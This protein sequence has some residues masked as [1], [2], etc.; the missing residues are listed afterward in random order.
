MPIHRDPSPIRA[1]FT[2]VRNATIGDSR[3]SWEARGLLVF[4]LSKPDNWVVSTKHLVGQ[5]PNAKRERILKILAEL[6]SAGYI[7]EEQSRDG[8]S[9]EFGRVTRV[10]YDT[11]EG[12]S[13]VVSPDGTGVGFTVSGDTVHGDA[14][15][16]DSDC[17][18]ITDSEQEL[19]E[20]RTDRS[21][22]PAPRSAADEAFERVWSAY[23]RKV[24]RKKALE[25]W[26]ARMREGVDPS[27]IEEAVANYAE[28]RR[29]RE[30]AYTMHAATFWG[31]G[32]RW[33]DW[34]DSGEA[35]REAR[36]SSAPAGF[37]GIADFLGRGE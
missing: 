13:S 10:V 16:G 19:N 7:R 26:R 23:P 31:P 2:I 37:S 3:L 27:D 30:A 36:S 22:P 28:A 24:N 1:N 35:T 29:G 17:I 34:L 8:S 25:V 18:V 12:P 4:L 9:G 20:T 21:T 14:V 6:E 11:P 33:R 15:S 5:S 32:E